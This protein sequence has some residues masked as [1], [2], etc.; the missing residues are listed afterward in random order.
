[1]A[2]EKALTSR[3]ICAIIKACASAQVENIA[4]G[5]LSIC[6]RKK[7]EE[8]EKTEYTFSS[9]VFTVS[10]DAH[11]APSIPSELPRLDEDELNAQI[12]IED[13]IEWERRLLEEES[14]AGS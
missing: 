11:N 7:S 2:M 9:P 14:N 3:D 5:E 13:P 1:M 8:P 6:F 4:I 10:G 12:A